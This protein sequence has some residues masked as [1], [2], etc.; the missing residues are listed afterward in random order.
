MSFFGSRR[1]DHGSRDDERDRSGRGGVRMRRF[2]AA[3]EPATGG[4]GGESGHSSPGRV[5]GTRDR[6][7]TV[8]GGKRDRCQRRLC[9]SIL[10]GRARLKR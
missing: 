8:P 4:A 5:R 7:E 9:L 2:E 6:T 3:R 10:G 1:A